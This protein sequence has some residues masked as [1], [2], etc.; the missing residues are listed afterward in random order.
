MLFIAGSSECASV[1]LRVA[2]EKGI[3]LK[4]I[5]CYVVLYYNIGTGTSMAG[6]AVAGS[7]FQLTCPTWCYLCSCCVLSRFSVE[8][9]GYEATEYSVWTPPVT[10]V[11]RFCTSNAR[12]AM[13]SNKRL[14]ILH[15]L[16]HVNHVGFTTI[17][18]GA[19]STYFDESSV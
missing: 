4:V 9:P 5:L 16:L 17:A 6:Q 15:W 19:S 18:S 2:W 10:G 12:A 1:N 3:Q 11:Q 7:F 13:R 14:N 8:E